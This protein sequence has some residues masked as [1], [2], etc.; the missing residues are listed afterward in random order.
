[1]G[2]EFLIKNTNNLTKDDL[3]MLRERFISDYSRKKG[4]DKNQLT[5][6]QL[7]EIVQQKAYANPGIIKS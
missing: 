7:L 5:P 4:W 2:N 3:T 1:M 6:E